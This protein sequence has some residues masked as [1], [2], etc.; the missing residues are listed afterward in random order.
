M[1]SKNNKIVYFVICVFI[2]SLLDFNLSDYITNNIYL[3]DF[4]PLNKFIEIAYYENTG[5]AFSIFQNNTEFLICFAIIAILTLFVLY[6]KNI[7][8][9]SLLSCFFFSILISGII[10]NTYERLAFGFVRDFFQINAIN[11]PVFNISDIL[12][13]IGVLAIM[14]IIITNKQKMK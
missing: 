7:N 6:I 2:T 14:F 8:N 11:F 3:F 9:F 4:K 10:C 13:N 5:A 12:I 1:L